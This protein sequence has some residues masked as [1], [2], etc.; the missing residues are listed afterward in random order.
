MLGERALIFALCTFFAELI[1]MGRTTTP[2]LEF[3]HEWIVNFKVKYL[4]E[5]HFTFDPKVLLYK[6]FTALVEQTWESALLR[7]SAFR[8]GL[9]FEFTTCLMTDMQL[10]QQVYDT[11]QLYLRDLGVASLD[12]QKTFLDKVFKDHYVR[13]FKRPWNSDNKK[14]L[15]TLQPIPEKLFKF[16]DKDLYLLEHKAHEERERLVSERE[17]RERLVSER[18]E[19]ER[20]V[21]EREERERLVSEHEARAASRK[22]VAIITREALLFMRSMRSTEEKSCSPQNPQ[23]YMHEN[24]ASNLGQRAS[25]TPEEL[26]TINDERE[27]IVQKERVAREQRD[28]KRDASRDAKRQ[29]HH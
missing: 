23:H 2:E 8:D 24:A 10:L 26:I 4:P 15:P 7:L 27:K 12:N 5:K 17:E 28:A 1:A 19:R 9:R 21:S 22:R 18:E 6:N 11:N 3:I 16:T 25:L 29:K 13:I 14:L 20:L